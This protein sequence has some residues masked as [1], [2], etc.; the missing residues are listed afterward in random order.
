MLDGYHVLT[1]TH[2]QVALEFI[3]NAVVR[4]SS[5]HDPAATLRKLKDTFHWDELYYLATCNRVI[6][7]FYTPL[8]L[9]GNL[10]E[11]VLSEIRPDLSAESTVFTAAHMQ[12]LHGSDAVRYFLEVAASMDSLVIGEREIIRQLREAY[13]QSNA[14][15][16]T[17]DHIRL[18]L[19]FTIETAKEVYTKTGIGEKALS[20][21]ALAFG[22]LLKTGLSNQARILMIGAGETNTLVAKFLS[23]Y[24]FHNVTIFNRTLSRAEALAEYLGGKALPL[25]ALEQYFD[26]FDAIIICTGATEPIIT[27]NLYHR[28]L[29]GESNSKVVVDLSIPHNV[30]KRV[31]DTFPVRYIDIESLREVAKEN[32]A[33][34]EAER[35][36]A[37]EL[38]ETRIWQYREIWHER[39]VERSLAFIPTEIRKI[40][41]RAMNEVF[42]KELSELNPEAQELVCRMLD[43]MEKKCIAVPI[44]GIKNIALNASQH[45][46]NNRQPIK[47]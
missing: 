16:L 23:K 43:Y 34:R 5:E 38:I 15:G 20:I 13:D 2:R 41:E 25:V 14:M 18:L 11:S 9:P 6:Y 29:A 47:N 40:K 22:E 8:P 45:H 28:L 19:K 7:L 31:C 1:L 36:K 10:T 35:K 21:V 4:T 30:D 39:Q 46:K 27:P 37:A 33:Y 3:G 12:M 26:G 44:K 42:G 24:G 32:L 17:G